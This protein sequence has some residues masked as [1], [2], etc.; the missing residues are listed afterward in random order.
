MT[1]QE[2]NS[3]TVCGDYFANAYAKQMVPDLQILDGGNA[4]V[5]SGERA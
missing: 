1:T 3:L 5:A 2:M 4:V